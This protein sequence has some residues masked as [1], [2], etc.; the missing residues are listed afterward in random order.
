ME[1]T[2]KPSVSAVSDA[3]REYYESKTQLEKTSEHL[4]FSKAEGRLAELQEAT[5]RVPSSNVDFTIID[6]VNFVG[7]DLFPVPASSS[8]ASSLI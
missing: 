2:E 7:A 3:L 8:S 5:G 6:L 4:R 1:A